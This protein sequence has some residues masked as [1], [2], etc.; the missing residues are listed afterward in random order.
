MCGRDDLGLAMLGRVCAYRQSVSADGGGFC[1]CRDGPNTGCTG[2]LGCFCT[3]GSRAQA[4]QHREKAL[5]QAC[6]AG[7]RMPPCSTEVKVCSACWHQPPA[8]TCCITVLACQEHPAEPET[9]VEG[10]LDCCAKVKPGPAVSHADASDPEQPRRRGRLSSSRAFWFAA[11]PCASASSVAKG[12]ATRESTSAQETSC[13]SADTPSHH[14][15][16]DAPT[17]IARLDFWEGP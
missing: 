1:G 4:T 11:D 6:C 9:G 2:N 5:H 10:G 16:Q 15:L 14:L 3:C 17:P 7:A 12:A 13:C 8:E